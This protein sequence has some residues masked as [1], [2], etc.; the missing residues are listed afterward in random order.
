MLKALGLLTASGKACCRAGQRAAVDCRARSALQPGILLRR[1]FFGTDAQYAGCACDD[2]RSSRNSRAVL[3]DLTALAEDFNG[4]SLCLLCHLDVLVLGS[5]LP[6][7]TGFSRRL[8]HWQS[9]RECIAP[10]A[11]CLE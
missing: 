7:H 5:V 1:D 9:A 2:R 11:D 4:N 10:V 8:I 6:Y 3:L